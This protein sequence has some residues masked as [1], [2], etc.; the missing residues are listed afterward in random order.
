MHHG[1]AYRAGVNSNLQTVIFIHG[2]SEG[3]PGHS[4]KSILDGKKILL[5]G[6]GKLFWEVWLFLICSDNCQKIDKLFSLFINV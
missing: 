2:F 4:G 1:E 3:S 6:N 5:R